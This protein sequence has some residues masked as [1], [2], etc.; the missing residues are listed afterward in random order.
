MLN[1]TPPQREP[2]PLQAEPKLLVAMKRERLPE[3]PKLN[4]LPLSPEPRLLEPRLLELRLLELTRPVVS[5]K[6]LPEPP[7]ELARLER[8]KEPSQ[9]AP[10]SLEPGLRVLRAEPAM[11]EL[12]VMRVLP[13][14][15]EPEEQQ[16]QALEV[17]V[18]PSEQSPRTASL[19]RS[20]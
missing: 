15:E 16:R 6:Q 20:F 4:L 10:V 7:P 12:P 11:R 14:L 18:A 8:A 9:R 3:K 19:S 1:P 17:L 5:R 13:A 2:Q